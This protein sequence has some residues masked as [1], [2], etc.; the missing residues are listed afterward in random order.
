MP[1]ASGRA[2]FMSLALWAAWLLRP[3][4]RDDAITDGDEAQREFVAWW[5]LRGRQNYP[6]APPLDA[7]ALA[8]AQEPVPVGP[9]GILL[10]RFMAKAWRGNAELVAA[11]DLA[12]ARGLARFLAWFC[13]VAVPEFGVADLI[14]AGVLEGLF[15]PDEATPALGCRPVN[16]LERYVWD[17][18]PV[19]AER[20]DLGTGAGQDSYIAWFDAAGAAGCG[21]QWLFRPAPAP[22]PQAPGFIRPLLPGGVNLIGFALGQLGVGEDVR[23]LAASCTAAGIPFSVVV[24]TPVGER[25]PPDLWLAPHAVAAPVYD[26]SILCMTGFD[27][28]AQWLEEPGL[29]DGSAYRIG[30][31]PWELPAWPADWTC[32]FELVDELWASSRYT[33]AAFAAAT[34]QPVLPM[35]LAVGIDRIELRAR[36]DFGLPERAFL[37]LYV[38]DANSYLARKNP[39]AAVAAFRRAFPAGDEPV[40]LVLKMMGGDRQDPVLRAFLDACAVDERIRVIDAVLPRGEVLGLIAAT[41]A[42]LSLHRAEGFGRTIAEAMLLRRPVIATGFSGSDELVDETTAVPVDWTRRPVGEDEYPF[43]RGQWWAEPDVAAAAAAMRDLAARPDRAAA[44][45]EA[46][47]RRVVARHA[48]LATGRAYAQRLGQIRRGI[49][50]AQAM[51]SSG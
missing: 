33:R 9:A 22:P 14:P 48:P 8:V 44:R 47:H 35:P 37:F 32:A 45:I 36:A 4:V 21:L 41:D 42:Y 20:F 39:A 34:V 13:L 50:Y 2:P 3:D 15:A 23:M 30:Y 10:P 51:P 24:R 46:A 1:E 25:G 12:D 49:R 16:R 6:K 5:A 11:H 27:T 28:A 26:V 38:F 17:F 40:G 29:A 18:L 19:V 43:G 7:A 31:W